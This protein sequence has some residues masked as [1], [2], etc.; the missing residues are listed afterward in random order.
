MMT[1]RRGVSYSRIF[2]HTS[3][4]LSDMQDQSYDYGTITVAVNPKYAQ[5]DRASVLFDLTRRKPRKGIAYVGV[6]ARLTAEECLELA[7]AL[8]DAAIALR[9]ARAGA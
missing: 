4:D 2:L 8:E 1:T 6:H 3:N 5:P 9:A 7:T